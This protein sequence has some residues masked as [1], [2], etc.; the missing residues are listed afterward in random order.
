MEFKTFSE[1]Q[2][3]ALCFW[4]DDSPYSDCDALIAKGINVV[5][6]AHAIMRKFE[7]PD[8][9]GSYDRWELKLGKKTQ[10]QT[11]PMV[12]E[13][14]DMVLFA[15]YKTWSIAADDK[16]KKRKAHG[17]LKRDLIP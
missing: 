9:M 12:K 16:G 2:L 8:E 3:T 17:T 4:H 5:Y 13:W 11:A 10:S 15:N 7:Q 1:K 14:A 6:T